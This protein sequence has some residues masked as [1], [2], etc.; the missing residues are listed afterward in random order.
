MAHRSA[1]TMENIREIVLST[2]E[3][4]R[5]GRLLGAFSLHVGGGAGGGGEHILFTHA[6][7]SARFFKYIT[8]KVGSG[9]TGTT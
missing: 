8:E 5:T 3:D 1:D 4:I 2:A 9:R 7:I 6:G